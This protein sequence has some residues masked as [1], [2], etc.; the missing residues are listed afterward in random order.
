MKKPI[1]IIAAGMV[2]VSLIWLVDK[3]FLAKESTPKTADKQQE[4]GVEQQDSP[5]EQ[6]TTDKPTSKPPVYD[7]SN[8]A[9]WYDPETTTIH[10]GTIL[11]SELLRPFH[12]KPEEFQFIA[13]YE[14]EFKKLKKSMSEDEYFSI[15][16][17][18]WLIEETKKLNEQLQGQLGEERFRFYGE[19]REPETH[20]YD[21][22][23]ILTANGISEERVSEFRELADEFNQQM[24][25]YPLFR[26]ERQYAR[27]L[28]EDFQIDSDEQR[29]IAKTFR[30]R[31]EKEFGK[32]VLDDIL[33]RTGFSVFMARLEMGIDPMRQIKL[34]HD[35][36]QQDRLKNLYGVEF[37]SEEQMNKNIAESERLEKREMEFMEEW[38]K[39]HAQQRAEPEES[40]GDSP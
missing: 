28:P 3:T 9:H 16:G 12:P 40:S 37:V 35:P 27:Y 15:D 36:K 19:V 38:A 17:R 5:T 21:T 25:G 10:E 31:I 30:D 32:Q 20:Y 8:K 22:W 13:Q 11:L 26:G 34:M 33:S 14:T 39:Y 24:H 2:A 23:K 4:S 18:T 7:L 29:R 6:R 1:L